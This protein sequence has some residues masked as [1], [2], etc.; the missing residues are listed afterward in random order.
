MA[1]KKWDKALEDALACIQAKPDFPKGWSRKGAALVG[2]GDRE[3]AVKAYKKCLD[4]D[5]S[6]TAAKN[7][8]Q[9]LEFEISQRSAAF[10]SFGMEHDL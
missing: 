8:L 3:G 5:S 1:S 4:L 10:S 2:Q 9:R 7:E 6:N